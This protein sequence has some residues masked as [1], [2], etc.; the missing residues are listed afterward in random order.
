MPS[1][2]D[3]NS[4]LAALAQAEADNQISQAAAAN[5]RTWLTA[6][7]YADYAADVAAHISQHRW[8]EL[9]DVFWTSIPFGTAG[10]RGR[11]YPIG[12]NAINDRTMAESAQGLADYVLSSSSLTPQASRLRCAIAYDTRHRSREFA[13]LCAEI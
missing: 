5:V 2:T 11:M 10:R 3:S 12:T 7:Q 6:P 8:R 9:E 1:P 4:A 13:Q